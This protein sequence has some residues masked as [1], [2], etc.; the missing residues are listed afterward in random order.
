MRCT[1]CR[2]GFHR[3][4]A[5]DHLTV[6]E[7]EAVVRHLVENHDITKVRLTG[8]D[9]T[10]RADILQIIE[11]IANI[12]AI[13]DLAMT[14]N[15]ISLASH[16][17]AYANAGLSRINVS[18]DSLDPQQFA[19]MT[20]VD[21]LPRVIEG[22]DAALAANIKP[23]K[24]NTVVLRNEN[25]AQLPALVRFAADRDIAIRFIELMPMGPLSSQWTEQYLPADDMRKAL[26]QTIT[27]WTPI[28]QGSDSALNYRVKLTDNRE[29]T[30]GF[31][32]PMSCN[33]CSNCDRIRL[34][35][36]GLLYPCLMDKPAGSFMPAV[37]PHFDPNQFDAILARGL[38][39][40]AAEHPAEGTV[41]MTNIGG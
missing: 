3:N 12:D 5:T 23:L 11:R 33:F 32:T 24:I 31:I 15:A 4:P 18:L 21:V 26:A 20:G 28:P 41:I 7:I 27:Q 34:A 36:D 2:P 1:Y 6:D 17:Q 14:T 35:A 8:G 38:N 9:P 30:V 10:A 19:R 22:I 25:D 39:Q 37:R 16:A 13:A 29:A 40:K